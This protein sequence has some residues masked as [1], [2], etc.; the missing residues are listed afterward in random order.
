MGK[1]TCSTRNFCNLHKFLKILRK[2]KN[3]LHMTFQNM[4]DMIQAKVDRLAEE[5]NFVQKKTQ[6]DQ[7]PW[8]TSWIFSL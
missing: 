5:L 3:I 6:N 7:K 4:Y 2:P 1:Y 8:T